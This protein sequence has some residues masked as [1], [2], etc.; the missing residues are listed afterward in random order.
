MRAL[1]PSSQAIARKEHALSRP[2]AEISLVALL[3]SSKKAR[4]S[5]LVLAAS[6]QDPAIASHILYL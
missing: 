6:P 1:S 4:A 5:R 2:S 3:L